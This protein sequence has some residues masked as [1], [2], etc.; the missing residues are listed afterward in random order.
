MG[1]KEQG[2]GRHTVKDL[3]PVC[4]YLRNFFKSQ[5]LLLY[6][7]HNNST[8]YYRDIIQIR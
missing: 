5:L 7:K 6:N 1:W 2:L 4:P 8:Y 3:C